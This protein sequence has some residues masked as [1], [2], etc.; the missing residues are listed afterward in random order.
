MLKQIK[1]KLAADINNLNLDQLVY[2]FQA[3][4]R[5]KET[6]QI[7]YPSCD[8]NEVIAK[9]HILN[10]LDKIKVVYF[11]SLPIGLYKS[12]LKQQPKSILPPRTEEINWGTLGQYYNEIYNYE[13][14]G[15]EY[16]LDTLALDENFRYRG[17]AT[18]IIFPM[19][20]NEAKELGKSRIYLFVLKNYTE[21]AYRLY[22]KLGFITISSYSFTL[23]KEPVLN[24]EYS[25]EFVLMYRPI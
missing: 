10:S 14:E 8:I 18:N 13:I 20:I 9:K 17:I 24:L 11:E 5:Y 12:Y 22:Q 3:T 21:K 15:G 4:G 6:A 25:D 7:K 19:I 23:N 2:W 16:F 1:I